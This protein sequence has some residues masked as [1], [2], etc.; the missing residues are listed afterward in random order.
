MADNVAIIGAGPCGLAC[1]RELDRLGFHAW[2]VFEREPAPGG[3]AGSVLDPQGFTW[4]FGG[5][6]VFS[7]YGEFD[8][9]LDD[10]MGADVYEHER[11]SFVR[12]GEAL[13]P[14]PFQN[15]LRYLE[16]ELTLECLLGLA[17]APGGSSDGDFGSWMEA[18]FGS[19]ITRL[20]M[21]PYNAKVWA[22][23][24]ERMSATWIA[25]RVS[26]VDFRRALRSVLLAE[27]DLG[28][29]PNN[30]FKF[31]KSGGTG[32]IYRRVADRLGDR[33]LFGREIVEVD[34]ERGVLVFSD[35]SVEEYGALVSTMPVDRLVDAVTDCPEQIAAAAASLEHT[36]VTVVGVGY[37]APLAHDWSW[38]YVADGSAP[39][40]RVTN[41]GKYSPANVP[42]GETPTYSS[43]LTET[44]FSAH[45]PKPEGLEQAVLRGLAAGG[46][47]PAGAP[48]ASVH[49]IDVEY[50]YPVPTRDRDD[51]LQAIQPWLLE[52]GIYSRGRFGSW[53]Y[54]LG[55]MDH[56]VKMGVDVA[57][58]LVEGRPEEIWSL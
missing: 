42:G 56:A 15:N 46:L 16:P 26:V 27:D 13:V 49:T 7:H 37:E 34:A 40:Y 32:E 2:R 53:R 30:T 5:H 17:A 23:P 4:D 10:V 24:L 47:A 33:V 6:V 50:A 35:G 12:L 21:Q 1:A 25:E 3:H 18:T 39:F 8:S 9:L 41:F 51:A 48:I 29:G 28:W 38:M 45:R 19:G 20:F 54:E 36:G 44:S 43:F 14:Y 58:F 55:N 31:P 11:S 57:R 22:T 52:R